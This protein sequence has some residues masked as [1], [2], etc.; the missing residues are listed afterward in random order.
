MLTLWKTLILNKDEYDLKGHERSH[1]L[2]P[3]FHIHLS[4]DLDEHFYEVLQYEYANF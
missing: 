2:I 3:F 4:T 1:R